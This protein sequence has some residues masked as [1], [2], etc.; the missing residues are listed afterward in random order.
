M[1]F[2]KF[3][4]VRNDLT[5][6]QQRLKVIIVI[7]MQ[8]QLPFI[9]AINSSE[10]TQVSWL[11]ELVLCSG[12][13]LIYLLEEVVHQLVPQ[14]QQ[15]AKKGNIGLSQGALSRS[16]LPSDTGSNA[17][18]WSREERV[19][20]CCE[21][22][23]NHNDMEM[24]VARSEPTAE[25]GYN[26]KYSVRLSDSTSS[27]FPNYHAPDSLKPLPQENPSPLRLFSSC[28]TPRILND[29]S[30]VLALSFHSVFEGL[31][32]GLEGSSVEVVW[33]LLAGIASHKFVVTFSLSL[34]LM[35]AGSTS[36]GFVLFLVTFSL[37]SPLGIGVGL[38]VSESAE[39]HT[40]EVHLVTVASSSSSVSS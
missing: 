22:V 26:P 40:A 14:Q 10:P 21:D 29:I 6:P 35:E 20:S 19:N 18:I 9:V 15:L 17:G 1:V 27:V 30:T 31:A 5:G 32:I 7:M 3:N 12:F 13:F 11:A 25:P 28:L 16:S 23:T 2:S 8:L 24:Q 34:Q 37:I 33:Q 38:A 36:F 4:Q 39:D